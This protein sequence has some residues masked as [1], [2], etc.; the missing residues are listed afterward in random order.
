MQ[1]FMTT[2]RSGPIILYD[3]ICGLCNRFVQF[4]LHRDRK[5]VFRF[6]SLQ[7]EFAARVLPRDANHTQQLDTVYVIVNFEQPDQRLL[8][9]SNAVAFVLKHIGGI[10]GA[11]AVVLEILPR[12]LRDAAYDLVARIRYRWFGK[13]DTCPLPDPRQ[14][15][16]FLDL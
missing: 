8:S 10:W 13:Y 16:K 12:R 15:Y 14:R 7:S 2:S 9:R 5:D 6:A 3:G 11:A 1:R 4:V